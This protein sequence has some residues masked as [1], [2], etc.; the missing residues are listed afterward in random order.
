M[1]VLMLKG[2]VGGGVGCGK[3]AF[4]DCASYFSP[5]NISE[6]WRQKRD[7]KY[8]RRMWSW[9]WG[10]STVPLA[11]LRRLIHEDIWSEPSFG[12]APYSCVYVTFFGFKSLYIC[13]RNSYK[14]KPWKYYCSKFWKINT[15]YKEGQS[16]K[17]V[18]SETLRGVIDTCGCT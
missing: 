10:V 8:R 17:S 16:M 5:K 11:P 2:D 15:K 3:G 18:Y 6:H 9:G 1:T 13:K 7:T 14:V 12:H 4:L